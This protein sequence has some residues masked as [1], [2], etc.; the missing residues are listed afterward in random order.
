[1]FGLF[2]D[3]GHE[4]DMFFSNVGTLIPNYTALHPEDHTFRSLRCENLKSNKSMMYLMML[5]LFEAIQ[6]V[7]TASV[8]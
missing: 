4:A 8:V 3:P 2:L 1:M 7:P 6:G 5:S